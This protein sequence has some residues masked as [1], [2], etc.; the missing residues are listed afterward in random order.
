MIHVSV[1]L[2]V[3]KES[4]FTFVIS[5]CHEPSTCRA[6]SLT[7]TYRT[8]LT[9]ALLVVVEIRATSKMPIAVVAGDSNVRK[10]ARRSG[11]AIATRLVTDVRDF[12][13]TRFVAHFT[14]VLPSHCPRKFS[15]HVIV[16]FDVIVQ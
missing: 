6:T 7:F 8:F 5:L 14:I 13:C 3:L 15:D 2:R 9:G 4:L 12:T 10:R 11:R 16:S 1:L